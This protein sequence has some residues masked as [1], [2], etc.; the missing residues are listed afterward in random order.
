MPDD[1]F[2]DGL[3]S[4]SCAKIV[5]N[6]LRNIERQVN[7]LYILYED[8]ENSDIKSKKQLQSVTESLDILSTG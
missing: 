3:S 7:E 1:I 5:V 2:A 8:T 6:C 4:P